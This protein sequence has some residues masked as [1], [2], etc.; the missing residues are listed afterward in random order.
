MI[1]CDI[2]F[3]YSIQADKVTHI[4][5]DQRKT[6]EEIT[7]VYLRSKVRDSF[8]RH[9]STMTVGDIMGPG[10]EKLTQ[11][12]KKDLTEELGPK[13]YNIDMVSIVGE[14]RVDE[15]VREAIGNTI[16]ALQDAIAAENKVKQSEAEAK[17]EV[18]RQFSLPI[19]EIAP[20]EAM[21][22]TPR[23]RQE[24]ARARLLERKEAIET[25]RLVLADAV[26]G[27]LQRALA[28]LGRQLDSL[29][30]Q[31]GRAHGLPDEVVRAARATL[32]EWR[33]NLVH[34]IRAL[35]TDERTA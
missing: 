32:E 3:A 29:P 6:I 27:S 25:G 21:S 16:K 18:F 20:D 28:V 11:L 31:L 14:M 13:G 33:R 10:K 9:A 34:E 5:R 19:D 12:V 4:F 30:G 17:Q 8:V 24:L 35:L 23:Q 7:A 1:N 2:A 22:L 15:K 26:A